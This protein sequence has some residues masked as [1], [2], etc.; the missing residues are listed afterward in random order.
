MLSITISLYDNPVITQK[1]TAA[2]RKGCGH[3]RSRSFGGG[4]KKTGIILAI[5]LDS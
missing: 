2:Q 1:Q 4:P 5:F 3:S